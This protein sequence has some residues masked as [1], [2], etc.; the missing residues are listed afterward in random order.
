MRIKE[1][2]EKYSCLANKYNA[3]YHSVAGNSEA[4]SEFSHCVICKRRSAEPGPETRTA[5]QQDGR[6]DSK[7]NRAV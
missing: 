6:I 4:D 7:G 1:W 5:Q 3:M 2:N